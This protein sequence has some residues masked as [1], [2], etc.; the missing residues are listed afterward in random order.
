MEAKKKEAAPVADAKETIIPDDIAKNRQCP[1]CWGTRRG[2]GVSG[3]RNGRTRY[4]VCDRCAH[5]WKKVLT[6]EEVSKDDEFVG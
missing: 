1:I 5:S 3:S 4:Y 2:K 6:I